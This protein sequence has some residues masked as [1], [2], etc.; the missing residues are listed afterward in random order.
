M[1]ENGETLSKGSG[2]GGHCRHCGPSRGRAALR[3]CVADLMHSRAAI[4]FRP[5]GRAP[6]RPAAAWPKPPK[7]FIIHPFFLP[8]RPAYPSRRKHDEYPTT[9]FRWG[10][11]VMKN[12]AELADGQCTELLCRPEMIAC[13]VAK[14]VAEFA[15]A[16]RVPR[17][18]GRD[19]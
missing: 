7:H 3:G 14:F 19:G 16:C 18:V 6:P 5:V 11:T 10:K 2:H 17:L 1:S 15:L 4:Y 13:R 9:H 12:S 8:R